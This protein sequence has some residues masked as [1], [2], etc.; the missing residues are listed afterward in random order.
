[1][2]RLRAAYEQLKGSPGVTAL[3]L[4]AFGVQVNKAVA[5]L[6]DLEAAVL[7]AEARFG[8]DGIAYTVAYAASS[9]GTFDEA[10]A[11]LK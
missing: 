9:F 3:E 1:M 6:E 11:A 2:E 7:G 8:D 10:L 4:A 5:E